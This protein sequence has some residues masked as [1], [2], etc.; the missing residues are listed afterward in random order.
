[1][2]PRRDPVPA[3]RR[4]ERPFLRFCAVGAAGFLADAGVL[5]T[6]VHGL[7]LDPIAARV[8][9]FGVA[10]TL[11]FELNRTWAF[12]T[13]VGRR[14]IE[15]FGAYL[16]VQG[17]GFACNLVIYTL[18]FLGLPKPLNAPILCLACASA[19]ALVV[20]YAGAR[21]LVFRPQSM[22]RAASDER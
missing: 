13:S 2:T 17:L 8:F 4:R 6:L 15:A 20:N 3:P 1:M 22:T 12:G 18:L 19:V 9:S 11:T 14:R 21:L 16:G 5:A 10:V 7:R